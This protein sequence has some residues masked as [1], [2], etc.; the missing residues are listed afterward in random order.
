MDGLLSDGKS[1]GA[2]EGAFTGRLGDAWAGQQYDS[3]MSRRENAMDAAMAQYTQSLRTAQDRYRGLSQDLMTRGSNRLTGWRDAFGGHVSGSPDMAADLRNRRAMLQAQLA[4]VQQQTFAAAGLGNGVF[5]QRAASDMQAR[6]AAQV[7][8]LTASRAISQ[9]QMTDAE[10]AQALQL[11]QTKYEDDL[12]GLSRINSTA[13]ADYER[14]LAEA[15]AAFPM[16]WEDAQHAGDSRIARA[17]LLMAIGDG[18]TLKGG[19]S[20]GFEGSGG[21][22]GGANELRNTSGSY[23]DMWVDD[24]TGDVWSGPPTADGKYPGGKQGS[25]STDWN[26]YDPPKDNDKSKDKKSKDKKGK[27]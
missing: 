13:R 2:W 17:N 26:S 21:K 20:G 1:T 15:V 5:D 23:N 19:Q 24:K 18:M 27:K 3:G 8:P 16:L 6:A 11:E 25:S 10:Y 9:S 7:D 14:Q 22:S 4:P 12:H